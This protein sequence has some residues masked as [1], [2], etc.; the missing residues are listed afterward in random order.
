MEKNLKI[1]IVGAGI[2][3]ISNALFLQKKGFS[4]TIFD[5]DEPG[6]P[7]ASYGNAGHFS[8]YASVPINRPDVLTDVP[9]MLLSSTGPLALK[10]NYVPKMM[11]WFLQFIRN[12]TTKRMMHTAKNMHQIL[13]LALPAYDELF[14]EVELG[15]LVEKKGILYIW[16]D[17]SLKSREL[18]IKVR[19]ELGVDQQVI[20][21]KEIH[22]L[23]PNIKPIYHGGVYYQYGRHA[24][25]P[26]K[27]LLKLYDLFLKKGGKFLKMNIKDINFNDEKPVI[28]A[29]T[30]S[31]LFDKIVIACGSF[32]KKLTDNLD[33]KIPLD[34]ERGYHVHFKNCDHLLSRPVIFQNRGFG[35]TPMEQGLR[36]VGT[37]EF[38][39]LDNPLSKS[40]VKN[41]INNA[42][43]MMG[44][45]PEHEDEWL[46]FR[47]TLPDYLPVIGP[48]KKYKNVFYCFGHHH[49]G[50][51]LGP[52]S[53]KII[54]GMIAEENTN[55]DLKPYSSL[56]FS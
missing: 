32:S 29:E 51:T 38:G 30:Q 37:V 20:T 1:G 50:W 39:G 16:N 35:I 42:K 45:L 34:T 46:G 18:E 26:K 12:C 54:S 6:S 9:A 19:N 15:G 4:V 55:L 33:E 40:R 23:E 53:G 48:S 24:R 31:F 2:Q 8:P 21:P 10:W 36:V 28:K 27:I 13:D 22:D 41:L 7:A 3:G 11:P 56:R 17:Q 25:N 52:I 49:L 43:Y 14:D 5:R 47:P 44:D